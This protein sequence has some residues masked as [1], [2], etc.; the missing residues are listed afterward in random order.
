MLLAIIL[1]TVIIFLFIL[2]RKVTVAR[3]EPAYLYNRRAPDPALVRQVE[4]LRARLEAAEAYGA[5]QEAV[6][7]ELELRFLA[8][9]SKKAA[10]DANA[11]KLSP[12]V[13]G[14]STV[15]VLR[16]VKFFYLLV[17]KLRLL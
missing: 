6:V 7:R 12:V 10:Y 15:D 9:S 17:S 4:S 13:D 2:S 8:L 14:F 16:T 3:A 11:A 5:A 1:T